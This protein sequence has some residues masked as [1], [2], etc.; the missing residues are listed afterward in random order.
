[1]RMHDV[2]TG[3]S[4]PVWIVVALSAMLAMAV[5]RFSCP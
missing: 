2:E 3:P 5:G 1:M 4:K